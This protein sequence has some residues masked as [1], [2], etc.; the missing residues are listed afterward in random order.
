MQAVLVVAAADR[1]ITYDTLAH[2]TGQTYSTASIHAALLSDG[3]GSQRGLKLLKRLPGADRRQKI[4]AASRTGRA[5]ATLFACAVDGSGP[6]AP[7][8]DRE[9]AERLDHAILP[10]LRLVLQVA[11]DINLG[12]F[13]ILLFIARNSEKFGHYGE[14]SAIISQALGLTSLS[15]LLAMLAEGSEERPG[16]GL[17]E[18]HKSPN[19]RRVSLPSLSHEGLTLLANVAAALQGKAPSP[20]LRPKPDRLLKAASPD[21]VSA[22]GA[23]AFDETEIE[24]LL[25]GEKA[26]DGKG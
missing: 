1:P 7:V 14:P 25:P 9:L 19:D 26:P 2:R 17:V 11:P 21:D 23:D 15:R 10:A 20:I 24:W 8:A 18:M 16:L 13:C 4:L 12:A 6:S 22:F 5:V 3:R